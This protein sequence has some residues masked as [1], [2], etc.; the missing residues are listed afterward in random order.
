MILEKLTVPATDFAART[1][2]ESKPEGLCKGES[3]V[4]APDADVGGGLLDVTVLSEKLGMPLVGDHERG[5]HALG[6]EAFGRSLTT[7]AAPDLELPDPTDDGNPFRLSS[8][9]GRKALLVAWAS[10]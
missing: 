6:P 5:L 2:W 8:L 7:A 9:H 4:P 3:C 10:W 1:G